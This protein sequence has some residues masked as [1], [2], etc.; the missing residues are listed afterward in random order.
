MPDSAAPSVW[1]TIM[2]FTPAAIATALTFSVVSSVSMS[3][4]APAAPISELSR[5]MEAEGQRLL[6][7]GELDAAAGYF[8]TA[9]VADPRNANAFIGLG[10]IARSQELPGKAIGF[11]REALA[12]DP[13]S[14]A[15]LAG[16][17][18]AMVARGA[19]DRAR[20]NLTRL[21][22]VCGTAGCD[23]IAQLTSAITAAGARTALRTEEVMPRPTVEAAPQA[24]N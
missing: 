5:A 18:E 11:F 13:E 16:Q 20:Q 6:A 2:R 21:Q 14:R 12:L 4:P 22:V 17:G 8:E 9:L 10:R 3:A 24:S 7:A 23:E 19:V 15:A 1:T